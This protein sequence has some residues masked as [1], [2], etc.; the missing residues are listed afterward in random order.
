MGVLIFLM[1]Q[2]R[3]GT[4]PS[5]KVGKITLSYKHTSLALGGTEGKQ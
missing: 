2:A 5:Y 3:K 4:S 1:T